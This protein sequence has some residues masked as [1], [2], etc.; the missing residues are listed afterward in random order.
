MTPRIDE[1]A[2][3]LYRTCL[4]VPEFDL[5]FNHFLIR[6]EEPLLFPTGMRGMFPAVREAVA[7]LI[8]PASLRWI[9]WSHFEVGSITPQWNESSFRGSNSFLFQIPGNPASARARSPSSYDWSVSAP[10]R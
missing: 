9:S 3:D 5:Q 6:D 2:T 1:V 7:S 8:D 10:A 4:Y